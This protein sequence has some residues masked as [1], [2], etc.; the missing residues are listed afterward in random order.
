MRSRRSGSRRSQS[1]FDGEQ[2]RRL[3]AGG[4]KGIVPRE[5][6]RE[7]ARRRF[8]AFARAKGTT[9]GRA[10]A[11]LATARPARTPRR[12]P[13]SRSSPGVPPPLRSM[14]HVEHFP[15]RSS[16]ARAPRTE[17]PL[18]GRLQ[19]GCST[20][21]TSPE[22][23]EG[24]QESSQP[25]R[26]GMPDSSCTQ[27]RLPP[28]TDPWSKRRASMAAAG[29]PALRS[30]VLRAS[31]RSPQSSRPRSSVASRL[32]SAAF[33]GAASLRRLYYAART[34]VGVLGCVCPRAPTAVRRTLQRRSVLARSARS[35]AAGRILK[36]R[37]GEPRTSSLCRA[38][39]RGSRP[40][41]SRDGR[42]E[43]AAQRRRRHRPERRTFRR[44]AGRRPG[45]RRTA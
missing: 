6:L 9:R 5:T 35:F 45:V 17:S 11:P 34:C 13:T 18:R 4:R 31:G 28:G 8:P 26:T 7:S 21:N 19:L 43:P 29:R 38:P 14:F 32:G 33:G 2:R 36:Q 10:T 24:R 25:R 3:R 41:P 27:N 15:L 12:R 1:R 22:R 40:I 30:R 23:P 37:G 39:R 20:W 16:D 42:R 44:A